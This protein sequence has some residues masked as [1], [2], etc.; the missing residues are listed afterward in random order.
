MQIGIRY[1]GCKFTASPYLDRHIT[2][3]NLFIDS[4]SY[5]Y[6][7]RRKKREI[8]QILW[9]IRM[10]KLLLIGKNTKGY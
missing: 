7:L 8:R 1:S 5:I 2:N 3:V 6:V 10:L 9:E 4:H